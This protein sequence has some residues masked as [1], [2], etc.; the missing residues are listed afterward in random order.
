MKKSKFAAKLCKFRRTRTVLKN[1]GKSK[2]YFHEMRGH[3]KRELVVKNPIFGKY[4]TPTIRDTRLWKCYRKLIYGNGHRW[5]ESHELFLTAMINTFWPVKMTII[6]KT[7]KLRYFKSFWGQTK[8]CNLFSIKFCIRIDLFG[9]FWKF[10]KFWFF[11]SK[12]WPFSDIFTF[13]T[14]AIL[15]PHENCTFRMGAKIN[16]REN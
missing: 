15:N 1:S 12:V 7:S 9:H 3:D 10:G 16:P 13:C 11:Y 4:L 14:S 5:I 6:S 8:V 2:Y